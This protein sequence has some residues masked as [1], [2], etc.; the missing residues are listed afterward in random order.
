M[1]AATLLTSDCCCCCSNRYHDWID[2]QGGKRSYFY[3]DIAFVAIIAGVASPTQTNALRACSAITLHA[4]ICSVQIVLT[5][6]SQS[7]NSVTLLHAVHHYDARIAQIYNEYDVLP[8]SIWSPPAN[9]YPVMDKFEYACEKENFPASGNGNGTHGNW[10]MTFP[11]YPFYSISLHTYPP[12]CA[13]VCTC[14]HTPTR[15]A[16]RQFGLTEITIQFECTART[17]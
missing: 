13:Q 2:D 8:G 14:T 5:F 7:N 17:D 9:L 10:N 16:I 4:F 12:T 1:A 3:V 11:M 15:T 6:I